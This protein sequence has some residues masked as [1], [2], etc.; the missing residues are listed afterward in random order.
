MG[1]L[2]MSYISQLHLDEPQKMNGLDSILFCLTGNQYFLGSAGAEA[3]F[4][5][6]FFA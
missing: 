5:T 6:P 2:S 4:S 1:V 3:D